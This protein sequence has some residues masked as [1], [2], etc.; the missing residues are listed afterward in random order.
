MVVNKKIDEEKLEEFLKTL[1]NFEKSDI[2]LKDIDR[3][4]FTSKNRNGRDIVSV[5]LRA[6]YCQECRS[7]ELWCPSEAISF[8][9]EGKVHVNEAKCIKCKVCTE[10]CPVVEFLQ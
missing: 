10:K 7:C 2:L 5:V 1:N 6:T 8:D 9:Q 3:I 4:L